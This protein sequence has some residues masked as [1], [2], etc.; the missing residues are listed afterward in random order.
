MSSSFIRDKNV[1]TSE[2][3]GENAMRLGARM[4]QPR[5][6]SRRGAVSS[7]MRLAEVS[8]TPAEEAG[9]DRAS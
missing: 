7:L 1:S 6:R 8:S 9:K 5:K 2:G 4:E 3:C